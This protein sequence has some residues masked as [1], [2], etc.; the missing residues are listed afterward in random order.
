MLTYRSNLHRN[1]PK[2][3]TIKHISSQEIVFDTK[4]AGTIHNLNSAQDFL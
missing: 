3:I 1:T 4:W 2:V